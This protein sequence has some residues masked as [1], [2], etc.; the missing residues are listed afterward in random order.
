MNLNLF[1]T[2]LLSLTTYAI[3]DYNILSFSGAGSFGSV[4]VN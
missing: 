1:V 4:K 2:V 3:S